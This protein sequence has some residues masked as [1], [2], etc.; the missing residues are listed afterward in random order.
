[1]RLGRLRCRASFSSS[2]VEFFGVRGAGLQRQ[3]YAGVEPQDY[4]ADGMAPAEQLA[5]IDRRA[6]ELVA[7]QYRILNDQVLPGLAAGGVERVRLD[8]LTGAE[9][10]HVDTLFRASIAP[11][12]TPLAIDPGHPFPHVHNKSLNIALVVERRNGGPKTR[13]HF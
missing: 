9:R 12:L 1:P 11:V 3:G 13:R 2:P 4:G 6:R 8:D 5:A 7:E 10:R